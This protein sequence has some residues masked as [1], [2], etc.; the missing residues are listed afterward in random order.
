MP[1]DLNAFREAH[2][3]WSFTDGGR[4]FTA[5]HVS[6]NDCLTFDAMRS[7]AVALLRQA[8]LNPKLSELQKQRIV[9]RH[10]RTD[11][12]QWRWLLRRAFPWRA[13]YWL[14]GDPVSIILALDAAAR[15]EVL[16][17]FFGCLRTGATPPQTTKTLPGKPS[18]TP[19]RQRMA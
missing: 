11:V 19:T 4:T 3:P 15:G 6:A 1:F 14:R 9:A 10:H 7:E 5:R 16:A 18:S 8:L 17:D 12:R 2:R 13:D